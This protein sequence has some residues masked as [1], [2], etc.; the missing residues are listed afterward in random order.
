MKVLPQ[1]NNLINQPAF[2]SNSRVSTDESG[3]IVNRNRTMF[4]RNDLNWTKFVDY[5]DEKYDG[6]KKPTIYCYACSDGSEPYTL[7]M[8]LISKLGEEKAQKFFPIIAKDIDSA[9]LDDANDGNVYL[10]E[11]D[12]HKIDDKTK[13]SIFK[14]F[15]LGEKFKDP[16]V[17]EEW[18]FM[19]KI[20]DDFIKINGEIVFPAKVKDILKKAVVFEQANILDDIQNVKSDN[21]V[22]MFRNAWK[23]LGDDGIESLLKSLSDNLNESSI[24]NIGEFDTDSDVNIGGRLLQNGFKKSNIINCYEKATPSADDISFC[25]RNYLNNPHFMFNTFVK[26]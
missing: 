15:D 2:K 18:P 7:A 10:T 23:Y 24:C 5:L 1:Y 11:A 3:N 12:F 13:R 20:E 6:V 19:D 4:L 16:N 25:G 14:F 22:V 9:F 8:M 17:K 26:K 21:S